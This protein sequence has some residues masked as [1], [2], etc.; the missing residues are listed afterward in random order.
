MFSF[1]LI[2]APPQRCEQFRSTVHLGKDGFDA[3]RQSLYDEFGSERVCRI[4][5]SQSRVC[6]ACL[7]KMT[8]LAHHVFYYTPIIIH[9]HLAMI[10]KK[11]LTFLLQFLLLLKS[12]A[13]D[14]P[15]SSFLFFRNQKQSV[16]W[17][18]QLC[19]RCCSINLL[20]LFSYIL[21]LDV[22]YKNSLLFLLL[23]RKAAIYDPLTVLVL[24]NTR[25]C[26]PLS[27]HRSKHTPTHITWPWLPMSH[28][29]DS[30]YM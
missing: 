21:L 27:P 29:I 6:A 7:K 3:H 23:M 15:F 26:A 13:S 1:P 30:V 5:L 22:V 20:S 8:T 19:Y 12:Y 25:S 4:L 28:M 14:H 24:H 11:S 17:T 18:K 2:P 10:F 16:L 9:E